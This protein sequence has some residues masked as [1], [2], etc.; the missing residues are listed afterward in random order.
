MTAKL[1]NAYGIAYG[2][3]RPLERADQHLS[4]GRLAAFVDRLVAGEKLALVSDAGT[5]AI[6]D[7]G[8]D[9]VRAASDAG[10]SVVVVPGPSALSA[11][12][13]GAGFPEGSPIFRGFFPRKNADRE[14]ECDQAAALPFDSAWI[15]FE[16]PERVEESVAF[17]ARRFPEAPGA[18]AEISPK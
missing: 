18:V 2:P 9:L 4:A 13:S 1:L 6:S 12:L 8:A 15:W 7:P 16:S 17:L 10:I 11:F 14:R 5:P 3:E